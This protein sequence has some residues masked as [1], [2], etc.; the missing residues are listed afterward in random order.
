LSI[1]N[2]VDKNQG[3]DEYFPEDVECFV[4]EGVKISSSVLPGQSN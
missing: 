1:G 2:S 4:V 3:K